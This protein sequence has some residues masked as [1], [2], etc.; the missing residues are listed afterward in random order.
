ME[1]DTLSTKKN[2]RRARKDRNEPMSQPEGDSRETSRRTKWKRKALR[3]WWRRVMEKAGIRGTKVKVDGLVNAKA[4]LVE[5][6]RMRLEQHPDEL[7]IRAKAVL[8]ELDDGMLV[9]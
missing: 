7:R 5:E 9:R 8:H 1:Q 2:A 6:L 3:D 4:R